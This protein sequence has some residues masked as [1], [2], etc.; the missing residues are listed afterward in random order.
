MYIFGNWLQ[1]DVVYASKHEYHLGAINWPAK[2]ENESSSRMIDL[3]T[4]QTSALGVY[5]E[6][7]FLGYV[8]SARLKYG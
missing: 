6:A 7:F 1:M 3:C 2:V 4:I 8:I 5:G